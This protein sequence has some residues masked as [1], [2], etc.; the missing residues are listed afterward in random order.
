MN[1]LHYFLGFPPYRSGGLTKYACDV[2]AAQVNMGHTVS[3][4]WPG[5]IKLFDKSVRIRRRNLV[6]GVRSFELINP[7]PVALDEGVADPASYMTP[8]KKEVYVAFLEKLQPK[9]IHIH[10]LMGLHRE[11]LDAAKQL[12]IRTVFTSHDYYGICPKV[13]LYRFGNV[14][15]GAENCEH[16]AA[17]NARGLSMKKILIM[18]SPL[19]RAVKN[20]PV[21][22][23]LRKRH[24]GS[25]FAEETMPE[26]FSANEETVVAYRKL[27]QYYM[28]MLA[29]V[30]KIHFN[31]TLTEQIYRQYMTPK[32]SCVI[33]I[34]HRDIRDNRNIS[35]QKSDFLRI[36]CLAPAKPFK[37]YPV[38]KQ[39]L[40]DLW[41][42]GK[43]NFV[44]RMFSPVPESAPYLQIREDGFC[45]SDLP[46]I[47]ADTDVLVA[48]SVWYET[49]GFTVLEALSF[50]VPVIITDHVGAQDVVGDGGIVVPAG[51]PDALR[52]AI[53]N[54]T[55]EKLNAMRQSV[56]Q[57]VHIKTW[58][59]FMKEN[60]ALYEDEN[61]ECN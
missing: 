19:Y 60:N 54:L 5:E 42:S 35:H 14:C 18:Q 31:S 12:G 15:Q 10:T 40:D 34:T 58:S 29:A 21:V 61:D 9:A 7:L 1:I 11:F 55:S 28:D 57:R 56:Q 51:S 16:C 23:Y 3:A 52:E 46:Q 13:T 27:R 24:R 33:S 59:E 44:L 6:S 26:M 22:R 8:C 20:N 41:T 36:T 53:A 39:A 50:G 32:D 17:C 47:M 37:G 48:P 49:F 30:D 2:M 4:L 38:L 45:Y 25:F 43:Q